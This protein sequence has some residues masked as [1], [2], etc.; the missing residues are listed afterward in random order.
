MYKLVAIDLDETL[1]SPKKE[2]SQ[3]NIDAIKRAQQA[4][5]KVIIATGR[6]YFTAKKYL[7]QLDYDDL[8]IMYGGSLIIKYPSEEI[9]ESHPLSD[10]QIKKT[11]DF[12]KRNHM[13]IQTYDKDR[14]L[15]EK[16]EDI[17]DYY[18]K[19]NA[20]EGYEADIYNHDYEMCLK[21]LIIEEADKAEAVLEKARKEFDGELAVTK[22]SLRYIEFNVLGISK[23]K[24][25][26]KVAQYY[27][28]KQEEVIAIGD[29]SNDESMIEYAGLGVSMGNGTEGLKKIA[30]Y[31]CPTNAESG[32]AH[33]IRKFILGED[34]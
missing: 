33:V 7:E 25:L 23:A 6:P 30:N 4:G 34:I 3:Q 20:V 2:I 27:G 17:F 31:I 16:R 26:A 24:A 5:A 9:I 14:I 28:V 13:F 11:I 18:A 1:L 19:G 29:N 12:A 8:A 32:V 22:S 21:T 15:Y 10:E